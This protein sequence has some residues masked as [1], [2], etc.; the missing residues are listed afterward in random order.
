MAIETRNPATGEVLKSFEP[1]IDAEVDE[2]IAR[3]ATA[4]AS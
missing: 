3:A 1:L 2:R 4:A